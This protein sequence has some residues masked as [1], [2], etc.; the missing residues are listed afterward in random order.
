MK[1]KIK[2]LIKF[3]ILIIFCLHL[4]PILGWLS[5]LTGWMYL[6][7]SYVAY[8]DTPTHPNTI[9]YLE[10]LNTKV[11][12]KIVRREGYRPIIIVEGNL[13][14]RN[15]KVTSLGKA[16]SLPGYCL[17][18]MNEDL[19]DEMYRK[20]VWHEYL[21]CFNIGHTHEKYD[22]MNHYYEEDMKEDSVIKYLKILE[23]Y[24]E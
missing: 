10:E 21:H 5:G 20:V 2:F 14:K 4:G 3:G 6:G 19:D 16:W 12:T 17:I 9:K 22:I 1:N 23:G 15:K 7:K 24:Y 11:T 13:N 18:V 8:V